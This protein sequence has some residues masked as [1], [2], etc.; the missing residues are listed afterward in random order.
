MGSQNR[1]DRRMALV[2]LTTMGAACFMPAIA[3][4]NR[5]EAS[6]DSLLIGT[7]ESGALCQVAIVDRKT[8]EGLISFEVWVVPSTADPLCATLDDLSK[9]LNNP[10]FDSLQA[11]LLTPFLNPDGL[12]GARFSC[13]LSWPCLALFIHSNAAWDSEDSFD[14]VHE[15][16]ISTMVDYR[17]PKTGLSQ[18]PSTYEMRLFTT[19]V[20]AMLQTVREKKRE[21]SFD[22][23]RQLKKHLLR[24]SPDISACVF[25]CDAPRL[26]AC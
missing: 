11:M 7:K 14:D 21:S 24:L 10:S 3:K 23:M 18:A 12:L 6:S 17:Y 13:V 26:E 15:P 16:L 1:P 2:H 22:D 19:V 25:D 20:L 9:S 5:P 8:G 4:E